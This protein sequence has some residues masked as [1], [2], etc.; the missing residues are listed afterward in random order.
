MS[1]IVPQT[2]TVS[3]SYRAEW[4]PASALL[5]SLSRSYH[6]VVAVKIAWGLTRSPTTNSRPSCSLL[7]IRPS[8]RNS[9][10]DLWFEECHP[11]SL[12]CPLRWKPHVI[13]TL[14][15]SIWT[16]VFVLLV[17]GTWL[18]LLVCHHIALGHH[19]MCDLWLCLLVCH[20]LYMQNT[21]VVHCCNL[22]GRL[23]KMSFCSC[24]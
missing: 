17:I 5:Q 20:T 14:I 3:H 12:K 18:S 19:L 16:D 1:P 24:L 8:E 22:L 4:L 11:L 2:H 13:L 23:F 21:C 7:C 10:Q 15:A 9:I 6:L